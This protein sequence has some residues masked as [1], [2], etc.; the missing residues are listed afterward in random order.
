[1]WYSISQCVKQVGCE[2]QQRKRERES[3]ELQSKVQF[4]AF[5][6]ERLDPGLKPSFNK[7]IGCCADDTHIH[8]RAHTHIHT[9]TQTQ[10]QVKNIASTSYIICHMQSSGPEFSCTT[11]DHI[12][13]V[14]QKR[15]GLYKC[16]TPYM[17]VYLMKSPP[18]YVIHLHI[19]MVLASPTYSHCTVLNR[20]NNN[21]CC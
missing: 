9:H 17:I 10:L 16:L 12:N 20:L 13:R 8:T 21:V 5:A 18:K 11:C 3:G 6:R 7:T 15:I 1:M 2:K 14:G 19:H 4:P